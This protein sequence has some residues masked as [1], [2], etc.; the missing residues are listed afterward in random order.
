M[1]AVIQISFDLTMQGTVAPSSDLDAVVARSSC[2]AK[3]PPG[4]SMKPE[5]AQHAKN[6]RASAAASANAAHAT[7]RSA[8]CIAGAV[9]V[10]V[11]LIRVGNLGAIVARIAAPVACTLRLL[12]IGPGAL[13]ADV[14]DPR[15]GP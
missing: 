4:V 11:R 15:A 5:P 9:V 8:T 14:P 13:L 2:A 7:V 1:G 3:A 10:S 12:R 6:H